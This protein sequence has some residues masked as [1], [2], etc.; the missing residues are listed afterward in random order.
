MELY[1]D[2]YEKMNK[3]QESLVTAVHIVREDVTKFLN[4]LENVKKNWV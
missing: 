4:D 3:I 2:L 1:I